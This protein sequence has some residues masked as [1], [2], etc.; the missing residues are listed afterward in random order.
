M[1][2]N[3]AEP[4][5]GPAEPVAN[6]DHPVTGGP[7]PDAAGAHAEGTTGPTP[8][9]VRSGAVRPPLPPPSAG[10]VALF[11]R[12]LPPLPPTPFVPPA[13]HSAPPG[14]AASVPRAG[15]GQPES[16]A[17]DP[18][19]AAAAAPAAAGPDTGW[20]GR[21]LVAGLA[22]ATADERRRIAEATA[23]FGPVALARLTM[24]ADGSGESFPETVV[25]V[26]LDDGRPAPAAAVAVVVVR[27]HADRLGTLHPDTAAMVELLLEAHRRLDDDAVAGLLTRNAEL[28]GAVAAALGPDHPA[29]LATV[30]GQDRLRALWSRR[31]LWQT[32]PSGRSA[33]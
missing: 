19:A 25:R 4:G 14:E 2:A 11:E 1:T 10:N 32:P 24:P 22:N 30:R 17:G 6:P 7:V 28:A 5:A 15:R 9:P 31:R 12:L 16:D 20:V 21:R 23:Q 33:T 26:L 8:A 13:I 18:A 27:D 3:P 29:A